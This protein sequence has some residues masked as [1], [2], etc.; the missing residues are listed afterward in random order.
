[1][2]SQ[3]ET[4]TLEYRSH[5]AD[6]QRTARLTGISVA[7]IIISLVQALPAHPMPFSGTASHKD[8]GK[9]RSIE[10][11]CRPNP[12]APSAHEDSFQFDRPGWALLNAFANDCIP[13]GTQVAWTNGQYGT[14]KL[15]QCENG[16]QCFLY[17][18]YGAP[19]QDQ[20]SY[21]L[22]YGQQNSTAL[23]TIYMH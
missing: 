16:A 5:R 7:C 4:S 1:M 14:V 15:S 8:R 2:A 9:V 12:Q 20:F 6:A 19:A 11:E 3:T 17:E 22:W 18:P 21:T 13:S 10:H 23:V